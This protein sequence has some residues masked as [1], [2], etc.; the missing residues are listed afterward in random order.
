MSA[1]RAITS[2]WIIF[3][4]LMFC[5]LAGLIGSLLVDGGQLALAYL[6][7]FFL[8]GFTALILRLFSSA[9]GKFGEERD[10]ILFLIFAWLGAP[11]AAIPLLA[12]TGQSSDF[13]LLLFDA[14][15]VVTTTGADPYANDISLPYSYYLARTM[16]A[17]FGGLGALT[18]AT[19]LLAQLNLAGASVHRSF[20][21]TW[22]NQGGLG[23]LNPIA[24]LFGKIL[25]LISAIGFLALLAVGV[26]PKQALLWCL[27]LPVTYGGLPSAQQLGAGLDF[28]ELSTG[29]DLVAT[30]LMLAGTLLLPLIMLRNFLRNPAWFR[31]SELGGWLILFIGLAALLYLWDGNLSAVLAT[32]ASLLSTTGLSFDTDLGG[33]PVSIA[34]VS[35]MI[36]GAAISTTGGIKV[37]RLFIL[38][39]YVQADLRRIARPHGVL[40]P[41]F[42]QRALHSQAFWGAWVYF[43]TFITAFMFCLL[44][45]TLLNV[46]FETAVTATIASLSNAGPILSEFSADKG[47][48]WASFDPVARWITM[49]AM[50]AGRLEVLPI[51]FIVNPALLRR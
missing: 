41:R 4:A 24:L 37:A 16:L 8:Y 35:V 45:L 50:L 46:E 21:F 14:V 31:E 20:L 39:I 28:G 43:A 26:G 23:N 17:W 19:S 9:A 18:T 36:G 32:S 47:L 34:L 7:V 12:I 38:W 25:G 30:G 5:S 51:L 33:I 3:L 40:P 11:I 49:L 48:S 1:I 42:S 2:C 13:S 22:G 10:A 15:S 27:A 44:S 29:V 6:L